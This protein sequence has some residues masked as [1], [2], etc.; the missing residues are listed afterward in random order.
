M[1]LLIVRPASPTGFVFSHPPSFGPTASL[2]LKFLSLPAKG[3]VVL[4]GYGPGIVL[5]KEVLIAVLAGGFLSTEPD[6]GVPRL[7]YPT[8]WQLDYVGIP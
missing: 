3:V 2:S 4:T 7:V 5:A 8:K 6:E 1:V